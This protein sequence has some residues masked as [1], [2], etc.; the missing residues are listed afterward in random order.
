MSQLKIVFEN[1]ISLQGLCN[2]EIPPTLRK[3]NF[4]PLMQLDVIVVGEK[5]G[6]LGNSMEDNSKAF[7]DQLTKRIKIKTTLVSGGALGLLFPLLP[8]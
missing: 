7:R 3:F 6:N 8:W 2:E 4:M 1:S 5:T